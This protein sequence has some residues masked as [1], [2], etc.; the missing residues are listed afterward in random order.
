[1]RPTYCGDMK[2]LQQILESLLAETDYEV[3]DEAEA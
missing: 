1:M 2:Y 3:A